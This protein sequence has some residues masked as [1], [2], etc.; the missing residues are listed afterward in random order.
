MPVQP[1]AE[2]GFPQAVRGD[3]VM[4]DHIGQV[5]ASDARGPRSQ[6]PFPI[7]L[8]AQC[9][10]LAAKA[11]VKHTYASEYIPSRNFVDAERPWNSVAAELNRL[12]PE[13]QQGYHCPMQPG[14]VRKPL[15]GGPAPDRQDF[16]AD[17]IT[18]KLLKSLGRTVQPIRLDESII[19]GCRNDLAARR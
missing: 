15:G 19:I 2:V 10:C 17:E 16:A 7:S 13:V 1:A 5:K 9:A 3:E 11:V 12:R 8:V 14:P 4:N 6:M 18:V